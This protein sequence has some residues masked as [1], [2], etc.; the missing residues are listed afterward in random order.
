MGVPVDRD[1]HLDAEDRRERDQHEAGDGD[2]AVRPAPRGEPGAHGC[3][4]DEWRVLCITKYATGSGR[5]P[6]RPGRVGYIALAD[7]RRPPHLRLRLRASSRADRT[8]P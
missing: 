5:Q 2:G 3:L 8:D 1:E 7:A 4:L 6:T